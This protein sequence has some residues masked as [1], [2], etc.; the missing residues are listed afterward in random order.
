[1]A[2]KGDA[3]PP[4]TS[5]PEKWPYDRCCVRDGERRCFFPASIYHSVRA[6]PDSG[7]CRLHDGVRGQAVLDVIDES[8]RWYAA[9]KAGEDVQLE[10]TR[11]D[12]RRVAGYPSREQADRAAREKLATPT[13]PIVKERT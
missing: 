4:T 10:Y 6:N 12:G 5:A 9:R 13:R 11:A 2:R 3:P 7:E 8:E 1:M